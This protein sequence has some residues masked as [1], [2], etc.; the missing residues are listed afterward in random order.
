M[1]A[2]FPFQFPIP[3]ENYTRFFTT[4]DHN[5][6]IN[7]RYFSASTV[8][9]LD[10]LIKFQKEIEKI[11]MENLFEL[12]IPGKPEM[13]FLLQLMFQ[14]KQGSMKSYAQGYR[15]FLKFFLQNYSTVF[16][17]DITPFHIQQFQWHEVQRGRNTR[18]I[19][20]YVAGTK[21]FLKGLPTKPAAHDSIEISGKAIRRCFG[22][23]VH[24]KAPFEGKYL[25]QLALLTD[26][27][28]FEEV[29]MFVLILVMY[30]GWLRNMDARNLEDSNVVEDML[31]MN[32]TEHPVVVL[33]FK[34][35]KTR[36]QSLGD[37]VVIGSHPDSRIIDPVCIIQKYRALRD[38]DPR[39]RFSF[40]FP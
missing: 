5:V 4:Y 13:A 3:S 18:F 37:H 25:V 31:E 36:D 22:C 9:V 6:Y 15:Q 40:L 19:D 33:H 1:W 16:F 35:T 27:L 10:H 38:A 7:D 20:L 34:D 30:L 8:L 2:L 29:R 39:S 24:K 23:P 17:L 11:E 21:F 28:D 12:C 32:N 26:W 14:V